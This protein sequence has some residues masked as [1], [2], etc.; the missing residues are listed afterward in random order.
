MKWLL[1][2]YMQLRY[3][4]EFPYTK[5]V[6]TI[7]GKHIFN[8]DISGPVPRIIDEPPNGIRAVEARPDN[9]RSHWLPNG[10]QNLQESASQAPQKPTLPKQA[11]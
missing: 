1:Q 11:L 2:N 10:K 8:L 6:I 4:G 7:P 9:R 3:E 5:A